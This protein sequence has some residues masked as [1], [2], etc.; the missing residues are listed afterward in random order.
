[1]TSIFFADSNPKIRKLKDNKSY[2]VQPKS[3]LYLIKRGTSKYFEGRMRFPFNA[4]GKKESVKIGVFEK[5]ILVEDAI[6]K[7]NETKV[8][9]KNNNKNPKLFG[10]VQNASGKTFKEVA[11]EYMDEVYVHRVKEETFNDRKISEMKC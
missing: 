5:E 3:G 8:W 1:M 4:S 7:W 2:P 9:S 6:H 10:K 11:N